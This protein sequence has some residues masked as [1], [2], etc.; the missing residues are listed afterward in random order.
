MAGLESSN[1]S[2]RLTAGWAVNG[3]PKIWAPVLTLQPLIDTRSA[4]WLQRGSEV[5]RDSPVTGYGSVFLQ[6]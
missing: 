3:N 4:K 5:G 1:V 6:S 2:K